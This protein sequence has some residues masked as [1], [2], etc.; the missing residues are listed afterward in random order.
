LLG[1]SDEV[2]L[3]HTG[4]PARATASDA[5]GSPGACA[6]WDAADIDAVECPP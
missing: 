1:L 5:G 2:G 4:V 3:P 6:A